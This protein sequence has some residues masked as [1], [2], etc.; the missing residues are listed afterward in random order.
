MLPVRHGAERILNNKDVLA[1]FSGINFNVHNKAHLIRAAQEGI[2]FTFK[3]GLDIMKG[4]GMEFGVIKAGASNLFQS[5]VFKEAF[6]NTCNVDLEIYNTDGS[7]GAARGAGIGAGC[8]PSADGA[9]KGLKVIEKLH[10]TADFVRKYASVYDVWN[11]RLS[12]L[13]GR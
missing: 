1:Q 8:Y 7:Q 12:G 6:V 13:T 2:V 10:P 5:K 9:F 3:Y 11:S 4:I